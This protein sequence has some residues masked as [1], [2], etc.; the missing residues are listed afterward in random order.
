[1]GGGSDWRYVLRRHGGNTFEEQERGFRIGDQLMEIRIIVRM[2]P[3]RRCRVKMQ[4][5]FMYRRRV[6]GR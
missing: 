4:S 1:M 5:A 3:S 6:G 2:Q